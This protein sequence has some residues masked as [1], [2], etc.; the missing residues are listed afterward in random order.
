MTL[1]LVSS[2]DALQ[3]PIGG[4]TVGAYFSAQTIPGFSQY[5]VA[6]DSD[7]KPALLIA[8][9]L[10]TRPS[11]PIELQ[12]LSVLH[13]VE[14]RISKGTGEQ[15]EGQFI[16][17]RCKSDDPQLHRYFLRTCSAMIP[18]LGN[19]AASRDVSNAIGRLV[20][21]FGALM[22]PPGK[23]VQGL[24]AELFLI[25]RSSDAMAL[26]KAW[27]VKADDLHDFNAGDYRIEVK[28]C[29]S[30][31][32]KHHFTAQQL[33][34]VPE[35]RLLIASLFANRSP[36]GISLGELIESARSKAGDNFEAIS[37][38]DRI[39]AQS[40][41]NSWHQAIN[42]RFDAHLALES[43]KFY[44]S[45]SIP[46][47]RP[48]VPAGVSDVRFVSDLS[49]CSEESYVSVQQGGGIFAAVIPLG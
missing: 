27:H 18:A 12:N 32:R 26:I 33:S 29:A 36:G 1:D 28:S 23:S 3:P 15:E 4:S 30:E 48:P 35:A 16:V 39:I 24:W 19:S 41:G 5:R 34:A 2:F 42:D 49:D 14:C 9:A 47:I 38:I 46:A 43:L 25:T 22:L 20:E 45:E 31:V 7:S 17:L 44:R 10:S 21:L 8:R 11:T 13:D 40:L 6:K 37:H